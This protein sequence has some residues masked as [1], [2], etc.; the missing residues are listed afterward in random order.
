[1]K[2][3]TFLGVLFI[4]LIL[5]GCS[6][7][8]NR[9][10]AEILSGEKP[11]NVTVE[12]DGETYE[13]ISGSYCW[14]VS[15]GVSKCVDSFAGSVDLLKGKEAIQV[16][17]SEKIILKM[18]YTPKPNKI[19]FTQINNENSIEIELDDNQFIAPDEKGIYFFD[20]GVWWMDEKVENTSLG[21]AS[22]AFAIEVK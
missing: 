14:D 12:V 9:S 21:S 13:T 4:A 18:D 10:T 16:K 17:P 7:S 19:H 2:K 22:Y 15:K 1:M 5:S 11:P 6:S 20:Y 3:F 8:K